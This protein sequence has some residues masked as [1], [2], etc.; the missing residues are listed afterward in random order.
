MLKHKLAAIAP[1]FWPRSR[2]DLA[3]IS[4]SLLTFI[5]LAASLLG[6]QQHG[7]LPA[8]A[9]ASLVL[10]LLILWRTARQAAAGQATR[11]ALQDVEARIGSV[12]ESAMDAIITIDAHQRIVQFN[13]SAEAMFHCPRDIAIGAALDW[14]IPDRYRAG[15]GAHVRQFGETGVSSRRMGASRIVMGLR[16]NG[17]EFPIDASISQVDE[18]GAK[19]YTVILRD[20]TERVQSEAE[21]RR[22]KAE[23]KE[24]ATA[25]HAVREQEKSRI[26]RELHDELGQALTALKMDV[27]WLRSH[28]PTDSGLVH[29]KLDRME[30]LLDNTVTSTR[31]ISTE[32]RPLILDDL[33]VIAAAE[34]LVGNFTT[35]TGIP[36]ELVVSDPELSWQDPLATAIFRICQE[37]LTNIARHAKAS[38]ASIEISQNDAA[39]VLIIRDDGVGFDEEESRKP[40]SFGLL[41]LRER[42]Y[43]LGGDAH[44]HSRPGKGT[45][46]E[47]SLPLATVEAS[48]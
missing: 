30:K 35:R 13:A 18:H 16:R 41:G 43:L 24:L 39:V 23:L 9:L 46:I 7:V 2:I 17:E 36:C 11:S 27:S 1:P 8:A 47:V 44:I 22:S 3:L 5:L 15:H 31:R 25:A 6:W 20:V 38:S 14:F 10:A 29:D 28:V 12:I 19:F 32:L 34:W 40:N 48:A 45:R 26:A 33:G 37:S 4:G 21:L 42:A